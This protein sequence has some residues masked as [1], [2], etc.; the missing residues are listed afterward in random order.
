MTSIDSDTLLD[1]HYLLIINGHFMICHLFS[2]L[3]PYKDYANW[4]RFFGEQR[5]GLETVLYNLISLEQNG[6]CC[7]SNI[8]I[9]YAF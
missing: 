1:L 7:W 5:N 4:K 6:F 3:D 9:R 2:D 8:E